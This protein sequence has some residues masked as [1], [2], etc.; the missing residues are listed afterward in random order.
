MPEEVWYNVTFV[1][2]YTTIT[3]TVSALHEYAAIEIAV[4]QVRDDTLIH[5]RTLR[6]ANDVMVELQN[7]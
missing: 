5:R 1:L 7:V 3:T 6:A 2:D 4:E